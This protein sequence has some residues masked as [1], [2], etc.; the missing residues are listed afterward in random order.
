MSTEA[1]PG[2]RTAAE[3]LAGTR[4]RVEPALRTAVDGLSEPLRH[5]AGY[6]LGWWDER[7]SPTRA[8][9]KA[10]RPALVLLAAEAVGG[11]PERAVPAAVAVELVHNSTLLH[12]DVIDGDAERRHRA[13][14]WAVFG[15]AAAILAGD[16]LMARAL[17][18][19]ASPGDPLA[20]RA[21]RLLGGATQDVLGGQSADVSFESRGDVG[22]GECV[23][24]AQAKTSALLRVACELGALYGGAAPERAARLAGFGGELGL[25]FQHVDD[26]LGIWGDPAATGKPVH[27]DLFSRK[28]T[29]PVVAALAAETAAGRELSALYGGDGP[30][31]QEEAVRAAELI[32]R[33]GGRAWSGRQADD[34]VARARNALAAAGPEPRAAAELDAL[35]RLVTDRDH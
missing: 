5:V 35:A 18:L 4:T 21:V 10:L 28:K 8:G 13:T 33:A 14:A 20:G 17:E 7:G 16:A 27:S 34:L 25:A 2:C 3:V 22:V 29:L 12:D 32:D 9:G 31:T 15:E 11:D 23:T 6:H 24:M 19:L 1:L 30:L 26:L